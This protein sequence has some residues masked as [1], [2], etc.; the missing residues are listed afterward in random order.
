M[1]AM[2]LFT[3]GPISTTDQLVS[4]DSSVLDVS[5][6]EGIDLT[7]KLTVAQ[8]ELGIQIGAMLVGTRLS[9][10]W[11]YMWPGTSISSQVSLNSIVT[12]PALRL[13]HTFQ[14]L[15]LVYR[16]AY[17]NQ[18]ND[19][20]AGKWS[21]YKELAKWA[22][23]IVSRSGIG[24]AA[25]PIPIAVAPTLGFVSGPLSGTIYFV[26]VSWINAGGE[27]GMPSR[28]ASLTV[29][30]QAVLQVTPV[31]PPSNA[32]L[33]NVYAGTTI[34]SITLQNASPVAVGQVWTEAATGLVTGRPPGNGQEPSFL[35]P[36]PRVLQRG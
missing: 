16:D 24:I 30:D 32:R 13:W 31:S 34:D 6:S 14:T 3:D 19:R 25:D 9:S 26:Q 4:Q 33:W 22:S 17:N 36:L 29:P 20:Y 7:A 8:E 21:E 23:D 27:E 11:A 10:S 28:L 12:T 2:A 35:K 5:S 15:A 18:L 1:F